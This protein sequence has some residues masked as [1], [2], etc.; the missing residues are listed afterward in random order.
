MDKE[1]RNSSTDKFLDPGSKIPKIVDTRRDIDNGVPYGAVRYGL[2]NN[3]I[4]FHFRFRFHF[5]FDS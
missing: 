1:I 3:L 4:H 5:D 2:I